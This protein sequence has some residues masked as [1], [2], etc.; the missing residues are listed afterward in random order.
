MLQTLSTPAL[1][2]LDREDDE[3]Q[4]RSAVL[5]AAIDVAETYSALAL[6]QRDH[7]EAPP[8]LRPHTAIEV[9]RADDA[10]VRAW[11]SLLH[12]VDTPPA[13]GA[14][15]HRADDEHEGDAEVLP[16]ALIE[17]LAV[18]HGRPTA[19]GVR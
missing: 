3:R 8:E 7:A 11:A 6:A 18:V 12:A 2:Q 14:G 16:P 4:R 10:A 17:H 9:M 5:S 13:P 1:V 19:G 15:R